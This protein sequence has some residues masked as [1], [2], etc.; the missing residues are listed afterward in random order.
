MHHSSIKGSVLGAF[1]DR[2]PWEPDLVIFFDDSMKRV[3]Q[4]AEEMKK[5]NIPFYGYYYKGADFVSGEL[6]KE[7]AAFQLNYL[8][9]H[10]KWLSEEEAR[11]LIAQQ[12]QPAYSY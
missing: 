10:E 5:R 4:V 1:L 7:V 6:D 11:A 12:K 9:E 8:V 3:E 2:T